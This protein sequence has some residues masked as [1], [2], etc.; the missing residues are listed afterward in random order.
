[1]VGRDAEFAQLEIAWGRAA[2][3]RG[4]IVHIPGEA[5]IGKSRLVRA[6]TEKVGGAHVWQCSSHHGS[7]S[8]YPVIQ[9]LERRLGLERSEPPERQVGALT[10]SVLDAGLDPGATVPFLAELLGVDAGERTDLAPIDAR[11]ATMRAIEALLAADAAVDPLLLVVEDL[12]WADPTTIELLGR[13]ATELPRHRVL[14]VAT[15]RRE[16]EP[17]W[18]ADR[19]I[20]LGP[21]TQAD[22]RAM[23]AASGLDTDLSGA[24]GVPLFIE[25]L[26][27]MLALQDGANAT[28]TT[29][30]PRWCR[31]R[32]RDC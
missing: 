7:T 24:D 8:L 2:G 18:A 21:L 30:R 22:V 13:L 28:A 4:A 27:K 10:R 26:L 25:E 29:P 32:S 3:G 31:R 15:Y 14:C 16:F 1:M 12:H 5:G 19:T 17:P 23:V 20:A 11:T 6:L 9:Y